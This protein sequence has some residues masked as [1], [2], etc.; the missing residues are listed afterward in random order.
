MDRSRSGQTPGHLPRE[1]ES[2]EAHGSRS[3]NRVRSSVFPRVD[4][5][6][7]RGACGSGVHGLA[8]RALTSRREA[9]RC[10]ATPSLW[11]GVHPQRWQP[12]A[13]VRGGLKGVSDGGPPGDSPSIHAYQRQLGAE[14]H[15]FG[16]GFGSMSLPNVSST[17]DSS[18]DVSSC[19]SKSPVEPGAPVEPAGAVLAESAIATEGDVSERQ[20]PAW[21]RRASTITH[22][23]NTTL[24]MRNST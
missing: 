11:N 21:N 5:L 18:S 2:L 1:I 13:Q 12:A 14:L 15:H 19:A 8:R 9:P 24:G 20:L 16:T 6:A 4:S 23:R 17:A 7:H 3:S 10:G 22:R